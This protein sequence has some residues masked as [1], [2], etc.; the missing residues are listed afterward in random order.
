MRSHRLPRSFFNRPTL[1]VAKELLGKY[2]VRELDGNLTRV[3]IVDVEAYIGQ[4]DLAC[5]AS[6]GRTKRTE[7]M[8]GPAGVAYVYLIYGMY[9]LLNIVTERI[10]FPA[11]VLIRGIEIT[12]TPK[13]PSPSRI[14]GPGKLTRF[15]NIDRSL[16][17]WDTTQGPPLWIEDP[18][19]TIARTHIQT[20][21]R[22]G[23]EYAGSW[24]HKPWRFCLQDHTQTTTRPKRPKKS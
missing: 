8:F 4:D 12:P 2:L 16:N 15:L 21:P 22:V 17:G 3:R 11:A 14:D 9:D 6:K 7:V 5:H 10:D 19:E 20:F 18:Q 13:S 23:I 24:A 1:R